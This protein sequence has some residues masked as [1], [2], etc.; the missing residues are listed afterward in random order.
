MVT[1][2]SYKVQVRAPHSISICIPSKIESATVLPRTWHLV[3]N[4]Y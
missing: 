1:F 2:T 3:K 4:T